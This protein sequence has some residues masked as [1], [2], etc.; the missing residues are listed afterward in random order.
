MEIN[1]EIKLRLNQSK[2]ANKTSGLVYL[3]A[4]YYKLQNAAC[5]SEKLKAEVATLGIFKSGQSGVEWTIPL[6]KGQEANFE[7][8]KEFR[9]KFKA[10]NKS[11]A[12]DLKACISRMKEFFASNPHVRVEHVLKA[13]D[14][15]LAS[16]NDPNYLCTSHYF[17]VKGKGL[18]RTSLL[19]SYIEDVMENEQSDS[20]NLVG[21]NRMMD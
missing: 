2:L 4:V 21:V 19:E 20:T 5:F 13:T 7:W 18:D 15:Y 14:N 12:G 9:D 8:V 6:F 11:R 10:V 17:I 16:V 3:I 1:Q